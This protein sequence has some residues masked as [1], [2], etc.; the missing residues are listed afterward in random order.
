MKATFFWCMLAILAPAIFAMALLLA[1]IIM[2][3]FG[4]GPLRWAP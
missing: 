3:L 1:G 4:V 2:D